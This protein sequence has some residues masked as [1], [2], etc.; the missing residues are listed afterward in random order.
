MQCP[1][2]M[3][4][5]EILGMGV[6]WRDDFLVVVEGRDVCDRSDLVFVKGRSLQ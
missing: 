1:L 6:G 5:D 3:I 2:R 4:S